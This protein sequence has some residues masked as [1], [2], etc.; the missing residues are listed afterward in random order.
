[1]STYIQYLLSLPSK[2]SPTL[3]LLCV[4]QT[5]FPTKLLLPT[6]PAY[7][8]LL[9]PPSPSP[10]SSL[11][12]PKP[13]CIFLPHTTHDISQF[14]TIIKPFTD[15]NEI[16]FAVR[17]HGGQLTPGCSNISNG[18]LVDLRNV[19][20]IKVVR[21]GGGRVVKISAGET[22]GNVYDILATRGLC[23]TGSGRGECGVGGS[24]LGGGISIF[25]PREGFVCDNVLNFEV[26]LASGEIVNAN[27][28]QNA[29]LWLALR[30]G[31]N[32][33]GIVTR[34]DMRTFRQGPIFGGSVSYHHCDLDEQI[35][36][37]V[38]ALRNGHMTLDTHVRMTIS[39]QKK[40]GGFLCTN[41]VYYTHAVPGPLVLRQFTEMKC[42]VTS[43]R[44]MSMMTMWEAGRVRDLDVDVDGEGVKADFETLSKVWRVFR[45][46]LGRE[47]HSD[48]LVYSMTFQ[49]LPRIGGNSLGLSPEGGPLVSVV[50]STYWRDGEDDDVVLGLMK[51]V[52]GRIEDE[53]ARR[54]TGSRFKLM[55]YSFDFQ[56]PVA[57]YGLQSQLRLLEVSRK[58]DPSGMFQRAVPGGSS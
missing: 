27:A 53:A 19:T 21:S 51:E 49:P 17:G 23:V 34:Y 52:L 16:M 5:T 41:Q 9:H 26:V 13:A 55:N 1:M 42:E 8:S 11:P 12:P 57:S 39:Y 40:W 30:G 28:N 58:Y 50:L 48:G 46:V 29:D 54:G 20:G 38:R 7:P 24:V 14:L 56:D 37:L 44:R 18:I 25:S 35:E 43:R 36:L 4:L 31:G 2:P 6:H 10:T 47:D 22:W 32:N 3:P 33:F 45:G 15:T